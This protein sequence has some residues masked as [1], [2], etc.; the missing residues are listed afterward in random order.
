M[1]HLGLVLEVRVGSRVPHLT[2]HIRVPGRYQGAWAI[3]GC[4]GGSM[5][6]A[7]L[8]YWSLRVACSSEHCGKSL[9]Q[10]WLKKMLSPW[11]DAV[12]LKGMSSLWTRCGHGLAS[13]Y[14]VWAGAG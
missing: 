10:C 11:E 6:V 9:H 5:Q 12:S 7:L 1:Q 14:Q 4:L 3:S 2:W 13:V 8:F